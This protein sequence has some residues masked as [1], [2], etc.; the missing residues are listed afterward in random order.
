LSHAA[1]SGSA[2][3]ISTGLSTVGIVGLVAHGY[4]TAAWCFLVIYVAPVLL[5]GLWRVSRNGVAAR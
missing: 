1:I 5:I 3:L 4:G 2:T